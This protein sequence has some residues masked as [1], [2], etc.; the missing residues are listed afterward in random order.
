M[1]LDSR[2]Q[3][4]LREVMANPNIR[5]K[6]LE[7]KL[8]LSRRQ[9]GYSFEKINEWLYDQSLP[10]IERTNRVDSWWSQNS[11]PNLN[12]TKIRVLKI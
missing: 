3:Y 9:L 2:S 4:L 6:E 10:K 7:T 12:W 8:R 1:Q 11:C 5:S